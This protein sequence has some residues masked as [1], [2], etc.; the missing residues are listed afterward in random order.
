MFN[1]FKNRL[2]ENSSLSH[3]PSIINTSITNKK[4]SVEKI[5]QTESGASE[6][7]QSSDDNIIQNSKQIRA[8]SNN[9]NLS[10]NIDREVVNDLNGSTET[11]EK[12][13]LL[14]N[15]IQLQELNRS[16]LKEIDKL[17]VNF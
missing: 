6:D 1:K 2:N 9:Q 7:N 8:E 15:K 10:P 16:L 4:K 11:F 14:T 5:D 17:H 13:L 12:N 3:T